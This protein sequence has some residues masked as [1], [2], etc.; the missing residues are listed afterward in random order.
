MV[1]YHNMLVAGIVSYTEIIRGINFKAENELWVALYAS[2]A[3]QRTLSVLRSSLPKT[4]HSPLHRERHGSCLFFRI[5]KPTRSVQ[6]ETPKN[7]RPSKNLKTE[8]PG[9]GAS[10]FQISSKKVLPNKEAGI[11]ALPTSGSPLSL[12]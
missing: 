2:F 6:E 5:L 11:V 12:C 7:G 8:S 1:S 3:A 9:C 10:Y 4:P